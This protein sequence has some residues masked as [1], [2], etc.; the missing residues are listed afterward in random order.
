MDREFDERVSASGRYFMSESD[1][2]IFIV[3]MQRS[4]TTL[5]RAILSSHPHIA[6]APETHYCNRFV[7]QVDAQGALDVS[8]FKTFWRTFS[9]SDRFRDLGIN[10]A[11]VEQ[12]LYESGDL[13]L[14][15]AFR[16]VLREYARQHGRARWGEKTPHHYRY[17]HQLL[18]WFPNARIVVMVRDPRAVCSSL[19]VVPWRKW[20]WRGMGSLELHSL[21][22]ARRICLDA[23]QWQ[24]HVND[25]H[26]RWVEDVR[27]RIVTYESL[28]EDPSGVIRAVCGFV[29]VPF[30]EAML[31]DR[32]WST[33]TVRDYDSYSNNTDR[34]LRNHLASTLA[35]ISSA[36]VDKWR[37]SLSKWEIDCIE[38]TC[39]SGMR[40]LGYR[41]AYET[42]PVVDQLRGL[43]CRLWSRIYVKLFRD[44]QN[45]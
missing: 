19:L 5:M 20:G 18:R 1:S 31:T 14:G 8:T 11:L 29:E 42:I 3:G 25:L 33:V 34:W 2:P 6:I 30:I 27:I 12:P 9:E 35:P 28:V 41:R 32:I 21:K 23:E 10:P 4:G 40:W 39:A 26:E 44:I 17:I 13:S 43:T 16:L 22:R 7:K 15:N 37:Q 24:R 36:A 45:S 38:M